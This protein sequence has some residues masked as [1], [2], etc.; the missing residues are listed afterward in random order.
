VN[1]ARVLKVDPAT[2]RVTRSTGAVHYV[3]LRQGQ[4]FGVAV[5]AGSAWVATDRA[6]VRLDAASGDPLGASA[7]PSAD[8]S[9]FVSIAYG[10]GAAWLTN[11]DRGTLVRVT[12]PQSERTAG[13]ESSR[14]RRK[15]TPSGFTRR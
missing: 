1:P 14:G 5:G 7:L 4:P 3:A 15:R 2:G 12:A 6:V 13:A 8:R 10:D 9:G 11:C